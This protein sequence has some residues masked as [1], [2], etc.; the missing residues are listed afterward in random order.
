VLDVLLE[1]DL[2]PDRITLGHLSTAWDDEGYLRGLADRG[3]SLAF[4]LFG[5]DHSLI[6]VGRWP[7][8]DLAVAGTVADLVR[9]GYGSQLLISGDIGVRTRL[10]AYGSWGYAHIPRHV[11][12]LL[13][14]LGCSGADI[15]QLMIV[16]PARLLTVEGL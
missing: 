5:F 16:N 9:A 12:P 11:V 7:P 2:P 4:D 13:L 6:G 1:S 10:V 3:V 15:E 14:E 8:S